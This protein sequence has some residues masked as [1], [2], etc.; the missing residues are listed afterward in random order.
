[1]VRIFLAV[2]VLAFAAGWLGQLGIESSGIVRAQQASQQAPAPAPPAAAPA[3]KSESRVVRVDAIV[4]DKKGNYIKDLSANDFRVYEDNKQQEIT[5][6]SFGEDS[7]SPGSTGKHYLVLFFDNSTMDPSDQLQA[8]AAAA[9]FIDANADPDHVMAVYEFGG[10]L[11]LAQNFTSNADRLRQSVAG[12]KASSVSPNTPAPITST[13]MTMPPSFANPEADFGAYT[14]LLAIRSLAKNLGG[15][16]G[17]KSLILFTAGFDLTPERQSELT[18]TIDACNKAN[19]AI[20]P[21]DV[22]GLAGPMTGAPSGALLRLP[23]DA[24]ARLVFALGAQE[25]EESNSRPRLLLA[26]Y[27]VPPDSQPAELQKPGGGGGGNPGGGGTSPGGGGGGKGGSG[28]SSGTGGSGGGKGG[29]GGSGS[30]GGSGGGKGGT[31]GSGG[32]VGRQPY[33]NPNYT[34]PRAIIPPVPSSASVN[35]QVL[36]A[37]AEGTGGFPILNTNDLL[38][39]LEKIAR[40]QG[41]Y[42]LLGYAPIDSPEGSCHTLR[43]KVERGGTNVRARSGYCNVRPTDLLA[44]KPIE[45]ELETRAFSSSA[46]SAGGSLEASF[47]YTSPNEARVN[48]AMEIPSASLDFTKIKGKYHAEVNV[49]GIAYRP[50]SS[51]GARFSDAVILDLEKDEWKQFTQSPMRYQSQFPIAPGQYQ[52]TIVLSGGGQNFGKYATPLVIDAFDGKTFSL[53][54]VALSNQLQRVSDLGSGLDAELL[55]DRTP[56]LVRGLEI[57]PSGSNRF[58][59]TDQVVL[60]AQVYD[61]RMADQNPP[62]V[63]VAYRVV[64]QKTGKVVLSTGAIDGSRFAEKGKPVIPVALKVPLENVPPGTYR[65]ELQAADMGGASSQVRMVNFE[66]E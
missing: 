34:Q 31:G 24:A 20:Y 22:R 41:E 23:N 26:S 6:F 21:L 30:T 25:S 37:L 47:F 5:N 39:G 44:G 60:Y 3:I 55:A 49:L 62:A 13:G 12:I 32:G 11:Q 50:D 19:V 1:M 38:A 2:C 8:R 4:T 17:R 14:L 53:S 45:K 65:I 43:V 56:L 58:K 46:G 33:G 40:E 59:K 15:I 36:Y 18:A 10:S 27:R 61:P 54:G 28:G 29:T 42:Y 7:S 48:L 35:Q 66:E 16:P 51:I 9:K 63:H 57:V 64:D 52:L